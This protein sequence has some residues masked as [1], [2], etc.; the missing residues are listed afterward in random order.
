M[1]NEVK[2]VK[3]LIEIHKAISGMCSEAEDPFDNFYKG[4]TDALMA[5]LE[6]VLADC[7]VEVKGPPDYCVVPYK[8]NGK[9]LWGIC[10]DPADPAG[11]WAL[12]GFHSSEEACTMLLNKAVFP[13]FKGKPRILA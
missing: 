13:D 11:S 2:N 12:T 1:K 10:S 5:D 9:E 7:G 3:R 6:K 4:G 8:R